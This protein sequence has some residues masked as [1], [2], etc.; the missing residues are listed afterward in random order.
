MRTP[1]ARPRHGRTRDRARA[2]TLIVPWDPV[3]PWDPGAGPTVSS[4]LSLRAS[5][6]GEPEL[7]RAIVNFAALAHTPHQ[8]V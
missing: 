7:K 8:L 5:L 1:A 6:P 3:G 4:Q 2:A